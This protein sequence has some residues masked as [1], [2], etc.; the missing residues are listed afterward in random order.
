MADP[1]STVQPNK[2]GGFAPN[3][4]VL[5]A[6]DG[7]HGLIVDAEVRPG[8]DEGAQ[9]LATVD[10][11]EAAFGEHPDHETVQRVIGPYLEQTFARHVS[12]VDS[13]VHPLHISRPG[14]S[15]TRGRG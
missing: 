10:R 11:V 6:V 8:G 12:G 1:D 2:E 15:A 4:T 9:A 13:E 7:T 5:L 14:R 3:Y